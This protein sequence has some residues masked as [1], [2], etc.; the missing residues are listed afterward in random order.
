M[1]NT[2]LSTDN[3][4]GKPVT[5]SSPTYVH[6]RGWDVGVWVDINKKGDKLDIIM[7]GGSN[8]PTRTQIGHVA[9][10]HGKPHFTPE[11]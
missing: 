6:I 4:R 11:A 7:T 9:L 5:A 2:Y 8:N 10:K 1:P 3:S